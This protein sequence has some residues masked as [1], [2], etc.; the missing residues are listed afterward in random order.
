MRPRK[1]VRRWSTTGDIYSG[2]ERVVGSSFNDSLTGNAGANQLEGG[3]GADRLVGGA[4]NDTLLGGAGFDVFVFG[5]GSDSGNAVGARDRIQTW[6]A[7][8]LINLAAIDADTL[9]AGDQA[10]LFIG[11]QAFSSG[12]A[13]QIRVESGATTVIQVKV[14]TGTASTFQI[15]VGQ[16]VVFSEADFTL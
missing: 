7:G 13:G 5:T 3:N 12:T 14:G 2:I 10:F 8:D 1:P 11:S 15:E 4:G 9:S 16:N 6:D